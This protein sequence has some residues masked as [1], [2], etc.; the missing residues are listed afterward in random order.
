MTRVL[1]DTLC[2]TLPGAHWAGH[3]DGSHDCWKVCGKMFATIGMRNDGVSVKTASVE[4]AAFLIE[5]GRAIKAPYHHGSWVRVPWGHVPDDELRD[6]LM[7][8]YRLIRGSLTKKEQATL[9]PIPD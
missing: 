5:I 4:D 1:T 2:A 3:E 7:T 9:A 8:S 6:R